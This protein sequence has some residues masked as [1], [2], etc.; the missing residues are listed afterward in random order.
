MFGTAVGVER[1][2]H[3]VGEPGRRH[4]VGWQGDVG[5]RRHLRT[6]VTVG[7]ARSGAGQV[8]SDRDTRPA[9]RVEIAGLCGTRIVGIG[10]GSR[11]RAS[12]RGA[13]L[14]RTPGM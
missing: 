8:C 5:R 11:A 14:K 4:S 7:S 1:D 10:D 12:R 6:S 2:W 13:A 3:Q 9:S